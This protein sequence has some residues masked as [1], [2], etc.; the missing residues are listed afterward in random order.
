MHTAVHFNP[1]RKAMH[2]E[3]H[4]VQFNRKAATV[5]LLGRSCTERCVQCISTCKGAAL[6]QP[7]PAQEGHALGGTHSTFQPAKGRHSYP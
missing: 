1:P 6:L 3:A 2:W 5:A 7:S 4:T